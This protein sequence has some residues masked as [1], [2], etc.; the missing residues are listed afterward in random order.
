MEKGYPHE[1]A[2]PYPGPPMD[3]GGF[4]PYPGMYPQ[5]G[6]PSA[7]PH[8]G[9]HGGFAPV[10]TAPISTVT[11]VI[12]SPALQDIPAH[13]VCPFCQ[14]SVVTSTEHTPGLFS[15][16][17]CAGLSIFGC[18]LCCCIPFCLDSCSD[19]E[20]RCPNCKRTIYIYKRM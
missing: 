11:N 8:G 5:Q 14:Q 13:T 10:P 20:H 9:Y 15:W 12:V 7:P 19:V 6:Y 3:N 16:A 18:W 4:V 1:S 2:P 17:V